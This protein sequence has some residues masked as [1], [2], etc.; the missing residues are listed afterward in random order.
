MVKGNASE[1]PGC[2]SLTV[3]QHSSTQV[4]RHYGVE[5]SCK[6]EREYYN[7]FVINNTN[8]VVPMSRE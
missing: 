5:L 2:A 8:K 7:G 1:W 3:P 6:E 4:M